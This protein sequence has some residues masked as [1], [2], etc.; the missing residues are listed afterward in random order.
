MYIDSHAHFDLTTE[1]ESI[2]VDEIF[3]EIS[4]NSIKYVVQIA[5]EKENLLWAYNFAKKYRDKGIFFSQGIHPSS[6]GDIES[7]NFLESSIK[8]IFDNQDDDLLFGIGE[9]GLDYFRMHQTKEDQFRAFQFQIDL[10]KKYNLPLIIHTREAMEDTLNF[11]KKSNHRKGIMHCFPGDSS[12]AKKA[13]DL[14]FYISFAGNV[15]FKKALEI[16]D[17]AKYVPLDRILLETDSPYLTP[18]PFRGKKNRPYLISNTYKFIADLKKVSIEEL[19]QSI[20]ENFTNIISKK[21]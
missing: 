12:D 14:G 17:A 4:S 18:V 2:S 20:Y 8:T 9:C 10:A 21:Y 15:T 1:D 19:Q 3:Q 7:L 5:I 6:K 16:Q 11:L 13:L